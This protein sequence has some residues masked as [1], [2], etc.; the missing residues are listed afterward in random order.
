[1]FERGRREPVACTTIA[2]VRAI[3]RAA[4]RIDHD[5][6]DVNRK[7]SLD[8][9]HTRARIDVDCTKIPTPIN[10]NYNWNFVAHKPG[11]RKN[12]VFDQP[13]I[14]LNVDSGASHMWVVTGTTSS[15]SPG[16]AYVTAMRFIVALNQNLNP[17]QSYSITVWCAT[18]G[19]DGYLVAHI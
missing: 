12:S 10:P 18:Q 14:D 16:S 11:D 3:E 1:V 9:N 2:Q 7:G 5:E 4:H 19:Q 17:N 8:A 13:R 6:A 15:G